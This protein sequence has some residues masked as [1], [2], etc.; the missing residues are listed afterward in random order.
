MQKGM[1][2]DVDHNVEIP[3]RTPAHPVFALAV[4]AQP[5]AGCDARRIFT[6]SCVPARRDL[7]LGTCDTGS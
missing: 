7:A 3:W 6:V 1:V 2:L 4:E 5:L